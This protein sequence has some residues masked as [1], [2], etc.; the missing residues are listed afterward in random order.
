MTEKQK[1]QWAG[2]AVLVVLVLLIAW[3]LWGAFGNAA[4]TVSGRPSINVGGNTGGGVTIDNGGD[5]PYAIP[6]GDGCGCGCGGSGGCPVSPSAI[7]TVN[8]MLQT[9]AAA[10]NQIYAMGNATLN[11]MADILNQEDPLYAITQG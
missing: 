11:A 9:G 3:A 10:T 5:N 2:A 7:Q 8:Q 4:R 1:E 6:T